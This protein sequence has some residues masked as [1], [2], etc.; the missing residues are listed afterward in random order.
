MVTTTVHRSRPQWRPQRSDSRERSGVLRRAE[1][2][3]ART[4][5]ARL[6]LGEIV[7]PREQLDEDRAGH[8]SAEVRPEGH[9]AALSPDGGQ[10]A[11]ELEDEPVTEHHPGGPG[12][13]RD[14]ET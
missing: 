10:P 1:S 8:E 12:D 13:R 11:H 5:L 14:D 4:P 9:A 6:T 3:A 7:C 2:E